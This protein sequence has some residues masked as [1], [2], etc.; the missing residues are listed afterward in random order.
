MRLILLIFFSALTS[1][2]IAQ[3]SIDGSFAFSNDPA[4]KYSL[5][6]PS[7]YDD[8]TPNALMLGFHPFNTNRWDAQ[9]WRDTLIVFAETNDL[10]LVC[11][12]GGLDGQVD[13][14]VDLAFTTALLDS[15]AVWYNVDQSQKY[16]IGFSVGGRATYTYGLD[17]A[18]EFQGFI[19]IGAAINGIQE[20]AGRLQNAENKKFYLVHG[21]NDI[22]SVRFTPVRDA[23]TNSDA[24]VET[25]LMIGVGHTIDFPDRNNILTEAF[26]WVS[27][28]DNCLVNNIADLDGPQTEITIATLNADGNLAK[29]NYDQKLELE[30]VYFVN[31]AGTTFPMTFDQT[32]LIETHRLPQALYFV[33]VKFK[34]GMFATSKLTIFR[35]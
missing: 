28:P 20:V 18:E 5:Y 12:D 13:N 32:G 23:L 19:P 14:P 34:N 3:E 10:L 33:H 30:E 6:V 7:S 1:T 9:A 35:N 4:K 25:I 31:A 17:N 16:I 24:C 2:F 26:N 22:P 21:S 27:N 8:N 15:V 29:I 11:P